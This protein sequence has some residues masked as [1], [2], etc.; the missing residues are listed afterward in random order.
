M[1]STTVHRGAATRP[2]QQHAS[3]TTLWSILTIEPERKDVG[4]DIIRH[5]VA[6]LSS[7]VPAGEGYRFRLSRTLES[8]HQAVLLHLLATDDV[9]QRLWKFA[10]ALAIENVATLGTVKT[11]HSPGVVYPPRP[12]EPVPG[13]VEAG[14]A[15]F[16]GPKG[17]DLAAEIAEVSSDLA[18]WAVNRFPSLNIRSMLAALILFDTGHAMMRG[19]RSAVW[20]DRRT[21][22]WDYYW[23]AHLHACTASFGPHAAQARSAMRARNAPRI[24]PAHRMM[25]A[26][27]SEPAVDIWRKRWARAID[28]YLYRADKQRVSRSALQ[29]AMGASQMAL[30]GLGFSLREQAALGLYASAWS[31]DIEAQYSG[32]GRSSRLAKH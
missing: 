10:D 24:V 7:Q 22:S 5:I 23:N 2:V 27:A 11:F 16:G 3:T 26:L 4:D 29:L 12:G 6:P 13:V 19:P 15:R 20:P 28:E 17:L 31:K 18:L 30:N 1:Q 32:E 8:D 14:L 21:T 9:A 25:A